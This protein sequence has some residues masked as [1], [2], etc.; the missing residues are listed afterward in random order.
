MEGVTN[1]FFDN[2]K[3]QAR[4]DEKFYSEENELLVWN[5]CRQIIEP[6]TR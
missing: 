6:Y 4:P 5:Y 1:A 3:K 2:K